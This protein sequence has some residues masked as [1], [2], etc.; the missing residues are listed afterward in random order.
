MAAYLVTGNPGS[1]KTTV[2]TE[3]VRRGFSALD[4]DEVAGWQS[5]AGDDVTQPARFTD[6]WLQSHRWV[7][8]RSRLE[9]EVRTRSR[10]GRD[11]FLCGIAMNQRDLLDLFA[12]VFLLTLDDAT[13]R[14]RLDTPDNAGRNEAQRTQILEGRPVFEREMRAVGAVVLDARRPTSVLVDSILASVSV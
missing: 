1:G 14:D 5:A 9:A 12:R 2:A 3:L 13:Q 4:A 7:W 10:A 6:D 11:L 8:S